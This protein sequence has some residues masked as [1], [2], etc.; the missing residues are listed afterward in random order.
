MGIL[1][2]FVGARNL[3]LISW[4]LNKQNLLRIILNINLTLLV[5]IAQ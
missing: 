1:P 5:K 4:G 2:K 3:C